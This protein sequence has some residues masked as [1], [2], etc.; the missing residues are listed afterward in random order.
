MDKEFYKDN[1]AG[2]AKNINGWL[3]EGK[4]LIIQLI[5]DNGGVLKTPQCEEKPALYAYYEDFDELEY[6]VSIQGLRYDEEL[7]L[8]ICTNDMLENYQYDTG[9]EFEYYR[10]F[11]GDDLEHL[12]KA[13][14]D[15]AYYVEIDRY[16]PVMQDTL[17]NLINGLPYYL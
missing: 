16:N 9:Y 15:A 13:L 10:N 5:K 7:G 6:H 1:L 11:E 17:I 8:C 3:T 14:D 12:N 2:I 4:D